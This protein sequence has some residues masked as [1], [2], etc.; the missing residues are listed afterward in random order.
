MTFPSRWK[1]IGD[2]HNLGCALLWL[3]MSSQAVVSSQ[4]S[5]DGPT[6]G[7]SPGGQ[8][9]VHFDAST[10]RKC[11]NMFEPYELRTLGHMHAL[12]ADCIV[13]SQADAA[14]AAVAIA[15]A[16]VAAVAAAAASNR[17]QECQARAQPFLPSFSSANA[18]PRWRWQPRRLPDRL[19]TTAKDHSRDLSPTVAETAAEIAPALAVDRT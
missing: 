14:A 10:C 6:S 16:E 3:W 7:P 9:P 19:G 8:L 12:T 4:P 2:A 1:G 15:L 17:S 5:A 13:C 18:L 11:V